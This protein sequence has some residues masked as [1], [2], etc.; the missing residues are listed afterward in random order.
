MVF[1]QTNLVEVSRYCRL[2]CPSS[3]SRR[4]RR[5]DRQAT[6]FRRWPWAP[7]WWPTRKTPMRTP[8]VMENLHLWSSSEG[9]C[10]RAA[11]C[12]RGWVATTLGAEDELKIW[13]YDFM[14][15]S[16]WGEKACHD[17]KR[18]A[19]GRDRNIW[20]LQWEDIPKIRCSERSCMILELYVHNAD[21]WRQR[22]QKNCSRHMCVAP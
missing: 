5:S 10:A 11:W 21:R 6:T 20:R 12:H 13:H 1:G 3:P 16:F 18:E 9:S 19:E 15:C 22:S 4:R 14:S 7:R 17:R 8:R 2:C